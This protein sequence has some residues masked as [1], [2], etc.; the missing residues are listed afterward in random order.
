[1]CELGAFRTGRKW[2]HGAW[3]E[4]KA[5]QER[6][7]ICEEN[8]LFLC[9][10]LVGAFTPI[11]IISQSIHK[12]YDAM[13]TA[14]SCVICNKIQGIQC[15]IFVFIIKEK[16]AKKRWKESENV[17][18]ESKIRMNKGHLYIRCGA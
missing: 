11:R 18:I 3:N 17:C 8:T 1:M 12:R 9:E 10:V 5:L 7:K 16:E 14:I 2:E 15:R 4:M 13:K 6:E